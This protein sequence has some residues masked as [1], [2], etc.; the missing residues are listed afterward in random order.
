MDSGVNFYL[1][2]RGG[3]DCKAVLEDIKALEAAGGSVAIEFSSLLRGGGVGVLQDAFIIDPRSEDYKVAQR[4]ITNKEPLNRFKTF[5][6][7]R[8]C[9]YR[10]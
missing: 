9:W 4:S 1:Y 8:S 2:T 3:D 5:P 7:E 6:C 10:G